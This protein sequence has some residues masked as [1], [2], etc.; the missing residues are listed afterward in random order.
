VTVKTEISNLYNE[1]C[2]L[3]VENR[4]KE[5]LQRL[6]KLMDGLSIADFTL[7]YENLDQTYRMMLE[8][9][10][11]GV[12][13]P[14]RER[15][16][17][18]LKI[19]IL[20]LADRVHQKALEKTGMNTFS[21]KV[22]LEKEKEPAKEYAVRSL[23]TLSFD[24]ELEHILTETDLKPSGNQQ[25]GNLNQIT[26]KLFQLIW[27]SDKY[28]ETDIRLIES[29]RASE[30]LPWYE[31]CLAVSALTLSLL[32]CFDKEK[33]LMLFSFYEQRQH[34]VWQRAFTALVIATYYYNR[35]I[36]L[37]PVI[38][39]KFA[40]HQDD[41][42]F[43]DDIRQ[44]LIA[45]FKAL[46]T[47]KVT[48]KFQ[49]EISPDI[50][51]IEEKIRERIDLD[52][53]LES[54]IMDDKNPDWEM[55]FEDSPGLLDKIEKMSNMQMDGVD[56][57]MGTFAMLKHFDFFRDI[58]NWF[59]PFYKENSAVRSAVI[60]DGD[61]GESFLEG[62]ENSFYMC[63]SD[64]FSFCFNISHLP[65]NQRNSIMNLFNMEAESLREMKQE[66]ELL[67]NPRSEMYVF[68]QYIQ[69]LYRF[70]KLHPFRADFRDIFALDW[71]I[72]GS[73]L[74]EILDSDK[75]L[76]KDLAE[77]LFE[78]E[79]YS[80]AIPLL[81]YLCALSEPSGDLIGKLAYSFQ[82]IGEFEKALEYYRQS[83]LFDVNRL[84]SVKKIIFCLRQLDKSEEALKWCNEALTID[85]DDVYINTMAGNCLFDMK[86][87]PE[88]LEHYFK[89]E[90]LAPDNKKVLR[91]IAWCSFVSGKPDIARNYLKN[92]LEQEPTA[93][94]YIN[95]GHVELCLRSKP[96]AIEYYVKALNQP[97]MNMTRF[98]NVI[99]ADAPIL[100][101][102]GIK[103]D[104]LS[105][106]LDYLR[107]MV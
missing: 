102:Q 38:S 87:F 75:L 4:L 66:E 9:T 47:E 76:V 5:A 31:K 30:E 2:S 54:N 78:K 92:I 34:E 69:D 49:Q 59:R 70:F 19:D 73:V 79:R 64:K 23:D 103:A 53:I 104:E 68:T 1:T 50:Q 7:Q 57:F 56:L 94:D 80:E 48:K 89:V 77:F 33:F 17:N 20:E 83:E 40:E 10:F 51:K 86:K 28:T 15:V 52:N 81:Q 22:Q 11:R 41:K 16:Y 67:A 42:Q 45:L 25:H 71:N 3:V 32:N 12:P 29:I 61:K 105:L 24:R 37:Y 85:P 107:Y 43:F 58:S 26:P 44:V 62:M 72:S 74:F 35:R 98:A 21:L 63:N 6:G 82:R 36:D 91:P 27:L 96:K 65:E 46:E 93:G 60:S 14:Q 84:W 88:A 99:R 39:E 101:S 8:Y 95:A 97:G 55:L 100:E 106:L 13:D 90:F 18:S